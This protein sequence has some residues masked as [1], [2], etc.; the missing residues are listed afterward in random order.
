[1]AG[2]KLNMNIIFIGHVDHGKSTTVGRLMF[3]TGKVSEQELAKLREIAQKVGKV[4]F[5]FAFVMDK[6]KEE[7]E[8]GL[9]I[10]LAYRKLATKKFNVT[11]IDAPGHKDFVKNMITGASQADAAFLVIAASEGVQ[12]Q[13]QEHAFLARTMGIQQVAVLLNKMDVIN[14]DQ[15]KF[16][17]IKDDVS[18]LLAA[19]GYNLAKIPFIPISAWKGDNITKKSEN[20]KWFNGPTLL[21]QL[22]LFEEPKKPVGLPLRMPIQDVY[23]I[24]G[25]GTVPVGKIET[26]KMTPGMKIII[27]P[28]RSGRGIVGEIKTVEMHHEQLKEGVAGDNVGVN[29]RG[30]G[31]KDI[32]RGDVIC[33]ADKPA[34]IA[35]EFTARIAVINHPTVIA[36]GYTPV[37][38]IHTSQVPC[39]FIELKQKLDPKTGQ[40]TQ[41]NPD[42]LKNGDVAVVRI[43]PMGNC[44]IEKQSV[45]PNM[46][47]FAVRD[48]GSTVA[49]GVCIELVE[50][51]F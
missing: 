27:L 31:K 40:V 29:I 44:V 24:T 8:R 10:D 5:E 42:F 14:Y 47:R 17:K 32:A 33:P 4:G 13:T 2:E 51:K 37:F 26:G 30:V 45:N 22:D 46:S 38:H 16:L 36:K 21:E 49:A 20:L 9:T 3:E 25:I 50:K 15:A 43:K 19:A 18:K 1:M 23:E 41:E 12:P 6:F 35:E 34:S 11:I 28:A 48:A 39:Q 7:R